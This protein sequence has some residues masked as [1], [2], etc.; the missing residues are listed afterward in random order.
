MASK[1]Y[2]IIKR[3]PTVQEH[4]ALWEAVGWGS[5][6]IEMSGQSIAGSLY[7]VVVEREGEVVGMGRVVGDGAMYF[8]I[9]D[10]AIAPEH[11][12][13][14]LGKLIVEQLLDYIKERRHENGLAFVGLFASHGNDAFY[15]QFGFKDHSPGMTGMFT[16]FE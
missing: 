4:K 2:E 3:L 16:V 6:H 13:Q 15:E 14:G 5:I 12:K 11:Q 10:V 1:Q 7:G 9:Q 8:Y